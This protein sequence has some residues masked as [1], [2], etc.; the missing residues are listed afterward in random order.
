MWLNEGIDSG[1]IIATE[2]T[3]FLPKIPSLYTHQNID[4][5]TIP[6]SIVDGY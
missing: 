6:K 1:N 4:V 3:I 5:T 2:R